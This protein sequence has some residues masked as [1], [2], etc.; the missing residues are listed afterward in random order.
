MVA[1]RGRASRGPIPCFGAIAVVSASDVVLRIVTLAGAAGKRHILHATWSEDSG[2][3]E[4]HQKL[5]LSYAEVSSHA[6]NL[7]GESLRCYWSRA[8]VRECLSRVC[9]SRTT[10]AQAIFE[11]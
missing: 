2:S 4:I 6:V 1:A 9:F 3:W 10:F 5:C 7:L 11:V 8:R